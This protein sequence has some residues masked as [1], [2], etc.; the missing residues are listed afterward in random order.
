MD[1]AALDH[2]QQC[3][4]QPGGWDAAGLDRRACWSDLWCSSAHQSEADLASAPAH[5]DEGQVDLDVQR[6]LGYMPEGNERDLRREQLSRVIRTTLRRFPALR[7]FQGFHDVV[8]LVLRTMCPDATDEA[9]WNTMQLMVDQLSLHFLRDCMTRDLHPAMGQ[10]KIVRNIVRAADAPYAYALESVFSPNHWI[11]ALPWVLTLFTHT[12]P[13][14]AQAQR[15]MDYVWCTGPASTLYLCAAFLLAQKE[16]LAQVAAEEH[17][18]MEALELAQVHPILANAPIDVA[19]DDDALTRVLQNAAY[20]ERTYPLRCPAVRAHLVLGRHSVLFTWDRSARASDTKAL[21][22]LELPPAQ[23]ALDPWPTPRDEPVA[24]DA[25]TRGP[26]T[27]DILRRMVH[28][29]RLRHLLIHPTLVLL[30]SLS[31]CLGGGALSVMLA[32]FLAQSRP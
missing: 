25:A 21:Q 23:L 26:R 16:R 8:G 14:V 7:Y 10:L 11:V 20:L 15:I 22:A 2:W 12:I 28:A 24:W 9:A 13:D 5:P 30:S 31:L 17:T 32:W 18:T 4:L 1:E 29:P 27:R 6:S 3:A 19:Q